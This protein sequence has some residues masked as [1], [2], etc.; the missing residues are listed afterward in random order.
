MYDPCKAVSLAPGVGVM[1]TDMWSL[2]VAELGLWLLH[3]RIVKS[4]LFPPRKPD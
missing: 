4:G 2:G 1:L 3:N